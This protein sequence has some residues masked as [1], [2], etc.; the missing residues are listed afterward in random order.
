[1][2]GNTNYGLV[3][4]LSLALAGAL[5]PGPSAAREADEEHMNVLIILDSSGSMAGK[6]GGQVKMQAAQRVVKDL[7][8]NMPSDMS[9]GLLVY[10]SQ[11]PYQKRDCQDITLLEPVGPVNPAEF[12]AKLAQVKPRGMTPI[13]ASLRRAAEALHGLPGKSTI[14]LVSDGAETCQSD[15]CKVA[16]EVRSTMGIDVKVHVVGLDIESQD[17]STLECV[18]EGGGGKYYGVSN[19]EQLRTAIAEATQPPPK[20]CHGQGP[21]WASIGH[22]GLGEMVNAQKGW[23]GVPKRKF[24]LGFIPGF[25]WPGYL[26]VV[27]AIDASHCRTNDWPND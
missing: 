19:E 26:Q 20:V 7:V 12:S 25:G 17:R 8:D 5:V 1:M 13:G 24:W 10:G 21:M 11:E 23:A 22:P 27:S 2:D 6:M 4:A 16:Q 14:V 15:P 18:A 9:V 3:L